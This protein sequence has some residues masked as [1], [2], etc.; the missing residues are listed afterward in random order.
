MMFKLR[1][2]P[3]VFVMAFMGIAG[4]EKEDSTQVGAE[5]GVQPVADTA[6]STDAADEVDTALG[7]DAGSAELA[8]SE[9]HD[10]GLTDPLF[11]F[12]DLEAGRYC[13]V[14][15]AFIQED[16]TVLADVYNSMVFNLCPQDLWDELDVDAIKGDFP[17]A[18]LVLLNGPRYFLMQ[19]L[20]DAPDTNDAPVV[21]DFGGIMMV[22][23]TTVV[24]DA[25]GQDSYTP[26][27]VNRDNTWRFEAG[28]RVHELIDDEGNIYIMQSFAQIVDTELSHDDLETL[29]ERLEMPEGWSYRTR[30]LETDLDVQAVG[31]A[32]VV[33]DELQ[34]TYQWRSDCQIVD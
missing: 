6:E 18:V 25:I 22:K 30:I 19:H 12:E 26:T 13:E 11:S 2:W 5:E 29:G 24:A 15:V 23:A 32:T 8:C 27:T 3:L 20:L 34:N 9:G 1:A 4:C 10:T 28:N 21:H 16:G 17:G 31:T 14:L 33:Q 7:V